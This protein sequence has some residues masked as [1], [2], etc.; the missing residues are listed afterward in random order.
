[1]LYIGTALPVMG[2]GLAVEDLGF[3][4]QASRSRS[5]YWRWQRPVWSRFWERRGAPR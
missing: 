5:R 4:R 2:V 1:V 3:L